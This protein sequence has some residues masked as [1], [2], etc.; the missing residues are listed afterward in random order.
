M[1]EVSFQSEKAG[2][3]D[4]VYMLASTSKVTFPGAGVAMIASS[5]KNIKYLKSDR[6]SVV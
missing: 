5:E 2:N 1:D 3:P 4:R 6:K